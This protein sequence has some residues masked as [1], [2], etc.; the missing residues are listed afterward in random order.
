MKDS[1]L[2]ILPQRAQRLRRGRKEKKQNHKVYEDK[3][4]PLFVLYEFL[5]SIAV[6]LLS[7]F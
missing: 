4:L 2:S 3:V 1:P 7:E 6:K 5:A